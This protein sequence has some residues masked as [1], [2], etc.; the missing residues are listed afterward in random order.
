M[1]CHTDPFSGPAKGNVPA[2]EPFLVGAPWDDSP[3]PAVGI[4]WWHY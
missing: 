2:Q 1:H 4:S 3:P